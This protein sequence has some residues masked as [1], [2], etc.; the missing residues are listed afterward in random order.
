MKSMVIATLLSKAES[1]LSRVRRLTGESGFWLY[2]EVSLDLVSIK[3]ILE[4]VCYVRSFIR[5][6]VRLINKMIVYYLL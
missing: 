6:L 3:L 5:Y 1:V 4:L 2:Q